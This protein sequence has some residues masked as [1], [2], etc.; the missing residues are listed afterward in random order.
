[1]SVFAIARLELLIARRN[2]WVTIAVMVMVLFDIVLTFAGDAPTG[3]L[4]V[5]PLTIALTSITT[6]SVYL[7]PLIALLLSFDAISGERERGTL[8]LSLSYPL[9]RLEILIGKFIA[10]FSVL[11]IAIGIGLCLTATLV[12]FKHG[13]EHLALAPLFKLYVT[14]LALGSCFLG[15]GYAISITVRQ[16][17]AA[18]GI[19]IALWL[20]CVVL[21][22]LALLGALVFDEAGYF[23]KSVFPWLL[24]SNPA[25][26]FRLINTPFTDGGM[27][28][29]GVSSASHAIGLVGQV[30][31]LALWPL[32]ALSIS[33]FFFKR[34]EP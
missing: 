19:A 14:S 32:I 16:S 29:S 26:A 17:G 27:I 13:A 21:Y 24:V 10:H 30:V 12:T 23:T 22:D 15:L 4:G 2:L 3:I 11:A 8:T 31:S 20:V 34:M 25:D 7:I 5:N 28:G 9:S 1:M 6:L 33:S 18:S